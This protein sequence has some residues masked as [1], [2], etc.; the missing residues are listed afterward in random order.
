MSINIEYKNCN[1]FVLLAGNQND[2]SSLSPLLDFM[3]P[4]MDSEVADGGVEIT[5]SE[6]GATVTIR[7]QLREKGSSLEE[8]APVKKRAVRKRKPR[9]PKA[10]A[11]YTEEETTPPEDSAQEGAADAEQPTE[12]GTERETFTDD[13]GNVVDAATGEVVTSAAGPA[14][15]DTLAEL[16]KV[17]GGGEAGDDE[18]SEDALF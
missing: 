1:S 7:L 16:N 4:L 5:R 13:D 2:P 11:T 12:A 6:D 17:L 9:K 3:D 15:P 8:E 14:S 18:S 10:V